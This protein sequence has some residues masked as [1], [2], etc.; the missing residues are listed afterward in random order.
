V[1]FLKYLADQAL[2]QR[3]N[4]EPAEASLLTSDYFSVPL[5]EVKVN[6]RS[7]LVYKSTMASS[8]SA[9]P[10]LP[11]CTL[12]LGLKEIRD[13]FSDPALSPN[14]ENSVVF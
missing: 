2:H 1:H 13:L 12:F 4:E 10:G 8:L 6:E 14:L 3:F 5:P 7:N 9:D 11:G